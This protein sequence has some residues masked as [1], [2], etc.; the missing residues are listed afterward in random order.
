MTSS[1]LPPNV[2]VSQHPC[3]HAKL[4][5]LRSKTTNARETKALVNEIALIVGCEAL[6]A[7]LRSVP[8]GTDESP[9]GYKYPTTIISPSKLALIPILRSGL[10][11]VEALETLLPYPIPVH[12]LGLFRERTSLQPV[13]YYNNLPY[14]KPSSPESAT[15]AADLAILVDPIIATGGTAVAAIQTLK[16][17]GVGRVVMISVLASVD[18][19]IRAAEEWE[20]GVEIWVGG[21]DEGCDDRG[22]IKPGLGDVGDRLFLTIGK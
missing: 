16:E 20:D 1:P 2:H 3:L 7:S 17:W 11:M 21:I 14:H 8:S 19:I 12:H 4:S 9:L 15:A 13:E 5:Q 22:M 6:G 10:G 18:G